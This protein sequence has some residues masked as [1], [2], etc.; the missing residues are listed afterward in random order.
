LFVLAL[1]TVAAVVALATL[2]LVFYVVRSS[3]PGRFRLS[4]KV[5]KLLDISIEVD[6]QDKP[7]ELP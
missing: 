6:A 5:L 3:K 2:A 1:A 4:A 7:K